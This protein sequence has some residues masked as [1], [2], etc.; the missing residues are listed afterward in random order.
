MFEESLRGVPLSESSECFLEMAEGSETR[1]LK[2][3]GE[4]SSALWEF[5]GELREYLDDVSYRAEPYEVI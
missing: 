1:P 5:D 2:S 3:T 4:L